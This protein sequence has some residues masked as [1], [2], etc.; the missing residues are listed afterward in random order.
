MQILD[1]NHLAFGAQDVG[2]VV[3]PSWSIDAIGDPSLTKGIP[4]LSAQNVLSGALNFETDR[5]TSE[6]EYD[7]FRRRLAI[8]SGDVLLTIV[9]T[10]G[11]AALV[12]EPRPAVFQ[13]SVAVMRPRPGLLD[14][15]FLFHA[16]QSSNFRLQL[17]RATNQSSQAGVYLGKLGSVTVPSPPLPEQRRIAAILDQAESLRAKRR[18]TL[19]QFDTLIHSLLFESFGDSHSSTSGFPTAT[20]GQVTECLDRL[21]KPVKESERRAGAIPYFGANGPQGWIDA[22]IFDEPLILIAE[23]GGHFD[24][25]EH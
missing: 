10:I 2:V 13:R 9:G 7:A 20:L 6:A 15:R 18:H 16:T 11:R 8:Q 3:H 25:P 22:A 14:G 5:F 24:A 4:V 21:R 12:L 23:D 17:D 1:V 19:A